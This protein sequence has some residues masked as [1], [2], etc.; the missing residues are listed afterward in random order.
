MA[1][2]S[3]YWQ[4]IEPS[5]YQIYHGEDP[6]TGTQNYLGMSTPTVNTNPGGDV[7]AARPDDVYN[8]QPIPGTNFSYD[9]VSGQ[10]YQ[11]QG[12]DPRTGQPIYM[13]ANTVAQAPNLSQQGSGSAVLQQLY[14]QQQ[15]QAQARMAATRAGQTGLERDYQAAIQGRAPSVAAAQ[16]YTGMGHIAQDQASQAAGANGQN[17]FAA[18]RA[19]AMATARAQG[20]LSGNLA[21]VRANETTAARS[22]LASLYGSEAQA[23]QAASSTAAGAGVNYGQLGEK[24]EADRVAANNEAAKLNL[25]ASKQ[26][27][28]KKIGIAKGAGSVLGAIFGG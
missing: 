22:G 15:Q 24:S 21:L 12:I 28:D 10:Y 27:Y 26:D 23:D 17:A 9:P 18:R 4:K 13:G 3:D 2:A 16:L 8:L 19:A 6:L 14:L 5:S 20:D 11:T 7:G 1:S 25:D